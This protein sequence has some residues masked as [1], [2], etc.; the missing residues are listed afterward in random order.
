MPHRTKVIFVIPTLMLGGAERTLVN[1]LRW[2]DT[3]KIEP[4]LVLLKKKGPYLRHVP[5]GVRIYD[6]E[7][8]SRR[9]NLQATYYA[10]AAHNLLIYQELARILRAIDNP[11]LSAV[12]GS[13]FTIHN[14]QAAARRCRGAA[15]VV[16]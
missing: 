2:I 5:D 15:A 11:V 9:H 4:V 7:R 3:S 8:R 6:L 13:Q 1:L 14:S 10:T 16:L 12:E